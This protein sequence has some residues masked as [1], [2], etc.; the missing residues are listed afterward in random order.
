MAARCRAV[1]REGVRA[2]AKRYRAEALLMSSSDPPSVIIADTQLSAMQSLAPG[3]LILD[4]RFRVEKLLG[5]GGMGLIYLAEQVSL[6]RRVAVKVLRG[7]VVIDANMSERFRREALLLSQVEHPA[8]VRVIDFGRTEVGPCLVMEL[9]EGETLEAVLLRQGA[10]PP[11]RVERLVMQLCQGLAAIHA[12]GIVHRDLKPEN[13]VLTR[14]VDGTEQ[15]RLLDFGIARLAEPGE[16]GKVT[17]AGFVLG[18]PEYISPEQA[19]GQPIDARADIY[20]LGVIAYRMVAGKHPFTGPS[21]REFVSQ[22]V[23]VLPTKLS[24]LKPELKGKAP[25]A[26]VIMSMLEKDPAKRPQTTIAVLERLKPHVGPMT[27]SGAMRLELPD[28]GT[29]EATGQVTGENVTPGRRWKL[30]GTLAVALVAFIFLGVWFWQQPLRKARRLVEARRGPEALQVLDDMGEA[31][32][33]WPGRML[34][35][36]ALHQASRADEAFKLLETIPEQAEL[37]PEALEVLADG[38]GRSE[39][40]KLRRL[41]AR[42][43]K[44]KVLPT[45]QRM[46]KGESSWAQWGAL[47]FVDLEYAG[48]GLALSKLYVDALGRKDCGLK[49]TAAKRLGELRAVEALEELKKL[50]ATPRKRGAADDE[51]G[52]DAAAA[53]IAKLEKEE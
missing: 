40:Q 1:S 23:Q 28:T 16:D 15:A 34:K 38:F 47:R 19:L 4:G 44:G 27:F 43:P 45:L 21:A 14:A 50:K 24:E 46:A 37:E 42:F 32:N 41:L 17:Q 49:R 11:E 53:A 48:Q 9:V 36:A 30:L 39:N 6:G 25:L 22:H 29:G 35:A 2:A 12:K 33:S 7:D 18:T 3:Q 5:A 51:C 8:V 10:L 26:G 52:Q 13:V 31:G 20:A